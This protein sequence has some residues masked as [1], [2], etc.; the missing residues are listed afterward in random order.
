VSRRKSL[1]RLAT[2][3]S[4][5]V[6]IEFWWRAR[7]DSRTVVCV[8]RKSEHLRGLYGRFP[9]SGPLGF[10]L[11]YPT[12]VKFSKRARANG[13]TITR[14]KRNK[15]V[16]NII[17]P[18]NI[19]FLASVSANNDWLRKP[20]RTRKNHHWSSGKQYLLRFNGSFSQFSARSIEAA[21]LAW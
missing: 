17:F 21:L 14:W 12:L 20:Y 4:L 6:K 11:E 1:R 13:G 18:L 16:R 7:M 5:S 19:F 8:L 3:N 15:S 9:S 2:F 10:R